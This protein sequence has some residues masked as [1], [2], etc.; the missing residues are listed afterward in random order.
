M[1]ITGVWWKG[2]HVSLPTPGELWAW[3]PGWSTRTDFTWLPE[4]GASV[5]GAL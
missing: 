2:P 5:C 4:E 3:G 1:K